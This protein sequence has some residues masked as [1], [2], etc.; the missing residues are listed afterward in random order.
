MLILCLLCLKNRTPECLLTQ[1]Q[2]Q[3][4]SHS[5]HL[6]S[7]YLK[8]NAENQ[9]LQG[10][11][12]QKKTKKKETFTEGLSFHL[13]PSEPAIEPPTHSRAVCVCWCVFCKPDVYGPIPAFIIDFCAL[14][15]Y[16]FFTF[17]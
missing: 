3:K 1:A 2:G 8:S 10:H 5:F 15:N 9:I 12:I 16:H 13:H 14:E 7:F 11:T 6:F 17:Q 4:W